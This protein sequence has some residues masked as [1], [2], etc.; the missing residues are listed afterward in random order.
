MLEYNYGI[1][2]YRGILMDI[3][4]ISIEYMPGITD[5]QLWDFYVRNDICEVG[6]GKEAAV[7]PLKCHPY[8][9]GAFYNQKLVGIIRAM[10]DGLSAVIMEFCLELKLQ[11]ED[12]KYNNGSLIE[13]DKYGIAKQMGVLL[14]D[15]LRKE[16]NTFTQAYIVK[17][18]EEDVYDSIG[19]KLNEGHL[20]Y[21]KDER[22]Y[23]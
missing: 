19:L 10:S 4:K 1:K 11:G 9:V 3:D 12:L 2:L 18:I 17:D 23:V 22:P 20:A 5:E 16:G 13:K 8:I 14:L 6:Y 15:N 7:K 21:I